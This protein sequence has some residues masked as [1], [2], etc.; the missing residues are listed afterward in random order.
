M[1]V[2]HLL[3]IL[4]I[5]L[6]IIVAAYLLVPFIALLFRGIRQLLHARNKIDKMPVLFEK[7][8]RFHF[9][10]TA[11]EETAFLPPLLD[12][13]RKQTYGN[14][15][16]YIVADCCDPALRFD[17]DKTITLH[18]ATPL[19][20]KIR[21]IEYAM[22]GFRSIPD[23]IIILDAD[24]LIHPGFLAELNTF[25]KKGYRVVQANFKAKNT[26][27]PFARMDSMGDLYNFF[28]ERE[29][30]MEAGLSSAIWGAG[31]AFDYNLYKGI[32]YKDYLGGF[33]KKLQVHLA[34]QVKQI[35]FAKDA[36]LYDEKIADGRAL[37]KQRTRW[38]SSQFKYQKENVQFLLKAIKELN[39][40]RIY[41]G[42]INIR[43][44]LFILLGLALAFIVINLF[45]SVN[46]S[47]AWVLLLFLFLLSFI[48]IIRIQ[49]KDNRYLK[50]LLNIPQFI[51]RQVLATL[52]IKKASKS[53]LKTTHTQ[54]IYIND[55]LEKKTTSQGL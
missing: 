50:T 1:T 22:A 8:F 18:P 4:F 17:D 33:D 5:L 19:N 21:S 15:V 24:N 25:F 27:T 45:F 13:I 26:D 44:P 46:S 54:V 16:T 38:I 53:F 41:F 14:Q 35:A 23:A 30:R 28:V 39:I 40:N 20:S 6:Q 7:D 34:S 52:K 2:V 12:S 31:I 11:H 43:P 49:S 51:F 47:I 42:F 48:S 3:K 32:R 10:I 37:E 55:I 29:M 9:I 36:I